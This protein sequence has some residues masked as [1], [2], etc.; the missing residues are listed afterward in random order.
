[1][2]FVSLASI[3][4]ENEPVIKCRVGSESF[5]TCHDIRTAGGNQEVRTIVT[6]N[7]GSIHFT[8]LPNAWRFNRTEFTS[9]NTFDN[10]F[11]DEDAAGDEDEGRDD[12]DALYMDG[13][14]IVAFA[15]FIAFTTDLPG[16]FNGSFGQVP[17]G[18]G[19]IGAK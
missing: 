15:S 8:L 19:E 11:K 9:L 12:S 10:G 1:M 6:L 16:E 5:D 3:I 4:L 7:G 14:L 17:S 2:S 18:G 13:L